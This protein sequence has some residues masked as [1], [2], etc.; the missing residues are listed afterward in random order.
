MERA[1]TKADVEAEKE[2]DAKGGSDMDKGGSD[3]G[4]ADSNSEVEVPSP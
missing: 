2:S 1:S 3:A 4:S